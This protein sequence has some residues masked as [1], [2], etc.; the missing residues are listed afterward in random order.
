MHELGELTHARRAPPLE[1]GRRSVTH[2]F[3]RSRPDLDPQTP[4]RKASSVQEWHTHSPSCLP[5]VQEEVLHTSVLLR[6][7]PDNSS[8]A[9]DL[10]RP[11]D[12]TEE[13]IEGSSEQ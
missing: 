3:T 2:V 4:L 9:N 7:L 6:M 1:C 8:R 11:P 13:R 5:A 12:E 10:R